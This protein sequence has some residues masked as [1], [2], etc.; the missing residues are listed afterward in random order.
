MN[1]QLELTVL[2]RSVE[3][4][5][6]RHARL[7]FNILSMRHM[8]APVTRAGLHLWI[9]IESVS[10]ADNCTDNLLLLL[11][12][13]IFFFFFWCQPYFPRRGFCVWILA[14]RLSD[15]RAVRR[16]HQLCHEPK[17]NLHGEC[18]AGS[19]RAVYSSGTLNP[20]CLT[21]LTPSLIP[22]SNLTCR[23]FQSRG[24]KGANHV[25]WRDGIACLLLFVPAPPHS[26]YPPHSL[27]PY[28]HD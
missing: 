8:C 2:R 20:A 24:S 25:T 1:I 14:D 3:H 23:L 22:A 5:T 17:Q 12:G 16:S 10:L 21:K 6:H 13:G 9:N 15:T 26:L 19:T 7:N 18:S 4:N 11:L 28:I 27:F